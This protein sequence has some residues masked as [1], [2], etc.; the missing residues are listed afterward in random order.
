M[1]TGYPQ[2]LVEAHATGIEIEADRRARRQGV[3][4]RAFRRIGQFI[5][6]L[7]GHDRVR[8]Y[9]QNRVSL[10]CASCGH[11]SHGW[12]L[13][14][15]MPQVRYAGDPKRHQLHPT[16]ARVVSRRVA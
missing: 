3:V 10:I 5:C 15:P 6:G 11:V 1:V 8:H 4:G 13:T 7:T 9:E 2:L 12:E 14:A 16:P